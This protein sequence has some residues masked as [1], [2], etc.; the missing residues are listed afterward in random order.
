MFDT[1]SIRTKFLLPAAAVFLLLLGVA[2]LAAYGQIIAR[3]Q[4]QA[5]QQVRE[6]TV[7]A[8]LTLQARTKL[9]VSSLYQ[10]LTWEAVGFEAKEIKALDAAIAKDIQELSK[11]LDERLAQPGLLEAEKTLVTAMLAEVGRFAKATK[12]TIDMKSSAQGLGLAAMSL[13]GAEAAAKKL[14]AHLVAFETLSRDNAAAAMKAAKAD[15][16]RATIIS[17]VLV[18]LALLAGGG[19]VWYGQRSLM[20]PI[21]ELQ[22]ALGTLTS[23]DLSQPLLT[24][25]KDEIGRLI[26]AAEAL[27]LRL[28]DILG[29]VATASSQ[30]TSAASEIADGTQDLSSRTEQQASALQQTAA[31]MEQMSG[32]V[33][34]NAEAARRAGEISGSA[35][36]VAAQG[37]A[38]VSRVISTM[39][40][41]SAQSRRIAEIIGVIDGIAFQTNIL[42]LNAAVEAARAGE[43]GRGFAVVASEVRSLAQRS[44]TAAREIKGLI[45]TSVDQAQ[46]GSALVNEAGTTIESMVRE[47]ERVTQTIAEITSATAEQSGG[48]VSVSQAVSHIDQMTQQNAAL[49]EQS[50]A[51]AESLRGQA[52]NL[53]AALAV[54][55]LREA[56]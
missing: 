48:I 44:A 18:A 11:T 24:T 39:D 29:Q 35:T 49:V 26:Q 47:V 54:F 32:T 40:E 56:H 14:Q 51:A 23:G 28:H 34:K 2:G 25:Q 4:L 6:N 38:V 12:D 31:S 41:I 42:A 43:Q 16:Q 13:T 37:S 17:A 5:Q 22:H 30:V 36:H 52:Q 10:T 53:S 46:R 27:R 19:L 7:E 55:K 1:L 9:L 8:A 3:A 45:A 33:T 50:S 20:R 15:L 21:G